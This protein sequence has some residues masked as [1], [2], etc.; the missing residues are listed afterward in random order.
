MPAAVADKSDGKGSD[1]K[2]TDNKTSRRREVRMTNALF[3][4]GFLHK[5]IRMVC[6]S[7]LVP[8]RF[9][10]SIIPDDTLP[11]LPH[12]EK[13]HPLKVERYELRRIAVGDCGI[14]RVYVLLGITDE[15]LRAYLKEP[16][17]DAQLR[18]PTLRET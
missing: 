16:Q 14:I 3:I 12:G 17:M 1:F 8:A 18:N 13:L 7:H 5:R 6:S 15:D 10:E 11:R 4:G 9:F 2:G